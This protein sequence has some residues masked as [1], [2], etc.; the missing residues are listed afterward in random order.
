MIKRYAKLNSEKTSVE[1]ILT[2]PNLPTAEE[3]KAHMERVTGIAADRWI[4]CTGMYYVGTGSK[5]TGSI[6]NPPKPFPS[7]ILN[8]ETN[9][10]ESPIGNPNNLHQNYWNEAE[11][12]WNPG[13]AEL[14]PDPNATE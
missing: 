9:E 8:T 10:W 1:E 11:G 4:D 13:P 14:G 2:C 3:C 5:W 12:I 7:W 6:F